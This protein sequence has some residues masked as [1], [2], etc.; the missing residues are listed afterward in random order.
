M[1]T[2][3]HTQIGRNTGTHTTDTYTYAYTFYKYRIQK[4]VPEGARGEILEYFN[5]SLSSFNERKAFPVP[6]V[7]E[8]MGSEAGVD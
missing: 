1:Y 6:G 8:S 5:A 7:K 2:D 4:E 3:S